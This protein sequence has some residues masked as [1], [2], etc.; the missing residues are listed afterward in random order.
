MQTYKDLIFSSI[1]TQLEE[2]NIETIVFNFNVTTGK[3]KLYCSDKENK[4]I[5]LELTT[6]ELLTVRM[7][8][9][10]KVVKQMKKDFP[11][12]VCTAIIVQLKNSTKD[13][14]IFIEFANEKDLFH[15]NK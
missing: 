13:F 1:G 3:A 12:K 10:N 4:S 14:D 15:L 2:N 7:M 8:F 9:I 11:E 5:P 6:T